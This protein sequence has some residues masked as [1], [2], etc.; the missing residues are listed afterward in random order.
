MPFQAPPIKQYRVYIRWKQPQTYSN[1]Y[2]STIISMQNAL[3]DC[4]L[5]AKN[6]IENHNL[7]KK[8]SQNLA[9]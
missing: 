9:G 3:K 2:Q 4:G 7:L 1:D 6:I 5:H 8:T